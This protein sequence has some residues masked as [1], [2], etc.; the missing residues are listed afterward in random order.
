MVSDQHQSGCNDFGLGLRQGAVML[1]PHNSAWKTAF[2]IEAETIRSTLRGRQIDIQHIGSSSIPGIKSKPI[3]D[4]MVGIEDFQAGP[5]L[6]PAMASIGYDFARHAG[7]PDDH[8]FGK[9]IERTHL[10]HVVKFDGPLWRHYLMFRDRLRA[11]RSLARD[12]E[13]LKDQLAIRF[14]QDRA[15]YTAA[16]KAFIDQVTA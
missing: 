3:L 4:L 13:E 2:E 10:V 16:K 14:S 1:V 8:V 12:Y 6:E 5:L 15:A 11:D 7:V 9:G